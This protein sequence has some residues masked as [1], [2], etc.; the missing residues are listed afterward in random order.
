[1]RLTK[2]DILNAAMVCLTL[3]ASAIAVPVMASG[4][5]QP[6]TGSSIPDLEQL[7]R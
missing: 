1:M 3:V 7:M 2:A 5:N 6:L 4:H